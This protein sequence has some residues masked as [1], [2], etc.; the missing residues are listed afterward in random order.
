MGYLT[1]S[2][3]NRLA[4]WTETTG[5]PY[6]TPSTLRS[7]LRIAS[8]RGE[9]RFSLESTT[10]SEAAGFQPDWVQPLGWLEDGTLLIQAR[11][12]TS[13]KSVL[14]RFDAASGQAAFFIEG[15]FAGWV[16]E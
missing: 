6:T 16:Y 5:D 11:E 8:I 10:F 2:P 15:Q 4:A 3:D 7:W 14:L 12:D 1:F 9:L 13:R